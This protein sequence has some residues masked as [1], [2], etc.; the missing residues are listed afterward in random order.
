[1]AEKIEEVPNV[2]GIP[3]Y[4]IHFDR[5]G[6]NIKLTC[7]EHGVFYDKPKPLNPVGQNNVIWSFEAK[8]RKEF[9]DG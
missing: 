4:D 1:M 3:E 8:H 9:H 6:K 2:P 5:R 7:T